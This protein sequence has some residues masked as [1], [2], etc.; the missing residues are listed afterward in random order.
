VLLLAGG[1]EGR[2]A[3]IVPP[4]TITEAQLDAALTLLAEALTA[5]ASASGV[6]R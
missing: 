1:P 6:H 2:V 5:V 3:Q 4:L